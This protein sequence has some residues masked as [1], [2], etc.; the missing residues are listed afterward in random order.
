ME[1]MGMIMGFWGIRF[2]GSG[3]LVVF[4]QQKM[5]QMS[6]QMIFPAK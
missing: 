1:H 5:A 3:S 4:G 6:Q 2:S